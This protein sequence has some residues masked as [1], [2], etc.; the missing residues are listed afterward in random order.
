MVSKKRKRK[1]RAKPSSD[2]TV[3]PPPRI[4]KL[5]LT[6]QFSE[7]YKALNQRRL[8]GAKSTLKMIKEIGDFPTGCVPKKLIANIWYIRAGGDTRITYTKA[9]GGI[10]YLRRVGGHPILDKERKAKSSN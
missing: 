10:L 9:K 1:K 3:D 6:D 4:T 8:A 2:P 7:D 5:R